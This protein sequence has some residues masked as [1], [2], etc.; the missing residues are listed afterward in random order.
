MSHAPFYKLLFLASAVALLGGSAALAAARA[1]NRLAGSSVFVATNET[2]NRVLMFDLT[3]TGEVT[4]T[5]TAFMTG[6]SGTGTAIGSQGGIALS[7][8]QALL[9]VVNPASNDIT[10]F[11]V[12]NG[13]LT[14]VEKTSSGGTRP[15]SVTVVRDILYV[16]N[17]GGQAGATD[18]I[19]GFHFTDDGHLTAIPGSNQPLSGPNVNPAQIGFTPN[20][21]ALVVT[22]KATNM[23]TIFVLDANDAA[24]PPMPNPSSGK[25]P[26]GFA[27]T[28]RA[29]VIVSEAFQ[30]ATD[31]SA[32]SSYQVDILG[33]LHVVQPSVAT[34]ETSA[35]WVAIT[36]DGD[37]VYTT[38]TKSDSVTGFSLSSEGVLT[39]LNA[40][41]KTATTG[42]GPIDLAIA[43]DDTA[44][45]V[46]TS[47]NGGI[48]VFS[49]NMT[50]GALTPMQPVTGLPL[51]SLGLVAH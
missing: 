44:V 24:G 32:V 6:G 19:N 5:A 40:D 17:A 37:F 50:T 31:A 35:C 51:S 28:K 26:F 34:T 39:L 30:D 2:T 13:G 27:V 21:K 23:L 29:R 3:S 20:G 9:F 36:E 12:D 16:L 10:V 14:M 4:P 25:T 15:I 7:G 41:G 46:L 48:S 22:E 33:G 43:P 8:A 42:A 1:S 18:R 11:H 45:Y 38:N 49:R 47:G